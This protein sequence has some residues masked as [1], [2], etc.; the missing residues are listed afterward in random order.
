[1]T[2]SN[3]N[4]NALK[5]EA[6]KLSN[7][8]IKSRVN[9]E[10]RREENRIKAVANKKSRNKARLNTHLNALKHLTDVEMNEYKKIFESESGNIDQILITSVQKNKDN[11]KDKEK[12]REYVRNLEL[13]QIKKEKYLAA[14]DVA[15]ANMK[16]IRLQINKNVKQNRLNI[17]KFK[18][19]IRSKLKSLKTLTPKER[20]QFINKMTSA[21]SKNV[22]EEAKK[23]NNSRLQEKKDRD[24]KL[25]NVSGE[26]QGLSDLSRENRKKLMNQLST[27]NKNEVIKR[28]R[29][30]NTTRKTEQK[31]SKAR[32][33][34]EFNMRKINGLTSDNISSFMKKWNNSQ[35]KSIL[36]DAKKF[37]STKNVKNYITKANIPNKQ[38][39]LYIKQVQQNGANLSPIKALVNQDVK[40]YNLKK[41]LK[42]N[43]ARIVTGLTGQYRRGWESLVND[44]RNETKLKEIEED[45]IKKQ[46]LRNRIEGSKIGPLKKRGHMSRVMDVKDDVNG[47]MEIFEQQLKEKMI[48]DAIPSKHSAINKLKSLSTDRKTF[49]KT[50][51]KTAKT[52]NDLNRIQT[53]AEQENKRKVRREVPNIKAT[54]T[55]KNAV[56]EAAEKSATSAKKFLTETEKM[57]AKAKEN[58]AFNNKLAE[59]RRL[60]RER[61][62]KLEPKKTKS[63]KRE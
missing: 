56:R 1:V 5:N 10:R 12:L 9:N 29:N 21:N 16:P 50:K 15:H 55:N 42:G 17:E 39:Q 48:E 59:K 20:L 60:L 7:F 26:L 23:L 51:F 22:L 30:L 32:Q 8:I 49:Y 41:Q 33:E 37:A 57:K 13:S 35:N 19:D 31:K 27:N 34:I 53:E 43:I 28:G 40:L 25:K 46:K 24:Q 52:I 2:G 6:R 44:T 47:R 54:K 62:A 61:E 3:T 58:R 45:L 4:F 18:I 36:D 14:I 38:K 63:K 11:E